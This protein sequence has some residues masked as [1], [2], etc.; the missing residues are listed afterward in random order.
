M[1][2]KLDRRDFMRTTAAATGGIAFSQLGMAR[3]IMNEERPLRIGFVGVGS[4]GSY[5]LDAALGIEGV[6]VPAVCDIKDA[7]LYRAR[8]WVEDAGQPAPLTW[9]LLVKALREEE[10][11]TSGHP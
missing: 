2:R 1:K 3:T 6:V 5:H 8:R 9:H 4:R 11:G 7:P 10:I